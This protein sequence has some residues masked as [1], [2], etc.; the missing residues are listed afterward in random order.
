MI[1][2][3]TFKKIISLGTLTKEDILR[4]VCK[5]LE[6]DFDIVKTK[7]TRK[8][9]Y[10]YARQLYAYFARKYTKDVLSNIGKFINKDHAT[11]LHSINQVNN[12]LDTD[13]QMKLQVG[14][15]NN[16]LNSKVVNHTSNQREKISNEIILKYQE[17]FR[18][19][20]YGR[21]EI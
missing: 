15:I 4:V 6:M 17:K 11:I 21:I 1:Y 12:F 16:A 3:G 8:R 19:C 9:E 18:H 20:D 13:K 5:E 14:K 7:E 2:L 10:V